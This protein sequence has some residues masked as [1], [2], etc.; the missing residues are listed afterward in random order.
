MEIR[1]ALLASMN[2]QARSWAMTG[3]RFGRTTLTTT[4]SPLR[5]RAACTWATEA[6]ASGLLSKRA[7]SSSTGAPS[8]CS[9]SAVARAESNGGTRSWSIASSS[10]MSGGSRSR[11]VESNWPNL[12]KIG[13]SPSSARR[14]R[15]PRDSSLRRRGI[16]RQGSR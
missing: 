16:Q 14:R 7:N 11:R 4:S 15:A 13:P 12:M 1:S 3:L 8:C 5:S 10:A 2:S 9:I 6:E